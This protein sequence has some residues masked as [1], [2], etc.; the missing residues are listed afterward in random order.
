MSTDMLVTITT[1]LGFGVGVLCAWCF[2]MNSREVELNR[3]FERGYQQG[4][5]A[6]YERI[7]DIIDNFEDMI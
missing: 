2:R 5:A 3:E 7:T 4:K 1:V 6:I